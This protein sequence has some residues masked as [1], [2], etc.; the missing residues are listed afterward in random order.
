MSGK[1]RVGKVATEST[2]RHVVDDTCD[3]LDADLRAA[4]VALDGLAELSKLAGKGDVGALREFHQIACSMVEWLNEK[5]PEYVASVLEWPVLLPQDPKKRV[6]ITEQANALRIGS[7]RGGGRGSGSGRQD[8]LTYNAQKGFAIENLRR[9]DFARAILR[10]IPQAYQY[11][12]DEGVEIPQTPSTIKAVLDDPSDFK[13]V[14]GII[15]FGEQLLSEISELPDYSPDTRE[16]WIRVM[17]AILRRNRHL[18]PDKFRD[19]QRKDE[20][21]TIKNRQGDD[22]EFTYTSYRGGIL[23]LT[24]RGGLEATNVSAVPGF[25]GQ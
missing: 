12:D 21:D 3:L 22:V 5:H 24:L 10:P 18:V 7:T 1:K 8:D 23:D 11:N 19:S 17:V 25:W 4:N 9:V 14:T 16:E 6:A 20:S 15:H 2:P 13:E